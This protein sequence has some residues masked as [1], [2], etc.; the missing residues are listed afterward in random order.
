MTP[1]GRD[2]QRT[3]AAVLTAVS[4]AQIK[5]R[6][7]LGEGSRD[8]ANEFG[9]STE[10]IRRVLRGDSWKWVEAAQE[11]AQPQDL[12]KAAAESFARLLKNNPQILTP[13]ARDEQLPT[14]SAETEPGPEELAKLKEYGLIR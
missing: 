1:D 10:T 5:R 2:K 7:M 9:V 3:G 13:T 14:G 8:L 4:V 12:E 11:Q 6:Y